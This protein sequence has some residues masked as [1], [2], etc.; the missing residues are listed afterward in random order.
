MATKKE[1]AHEYEAIWCC[2][3]VKEF[4]P[5]KYREI[6]VLCLLLSQPFD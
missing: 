6:N 1:L 5:N 4:P 3:S 2:G